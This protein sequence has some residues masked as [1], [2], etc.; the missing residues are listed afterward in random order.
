M[1]LDVSQI[2]TNLQEQVWV[3]RGCLKSLIATIK[4]SKSLDLRVPTSGVFMRGSPPHKKTTRQ[5]KVR[6]WGASFVGE[7]SPTKLACFSK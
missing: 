6:S 7:A 4:T 3:V 2:V 5:R 1:F